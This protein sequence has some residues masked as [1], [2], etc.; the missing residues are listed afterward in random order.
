MYASKIV[1]GGLRKLLIISPLYSNE[2][3][4]LREEQKKEN[5]IKRKRKKNEQIKRVERYKNKK[6]TKFT[7]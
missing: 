4:I 1:K 6:R 5:K 2:I 7:V 3:Q